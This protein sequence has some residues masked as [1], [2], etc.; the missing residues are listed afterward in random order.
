MFHATP[1]V[2]LLAGVGDSAVR[3]PDL[4]GV[5]AEKNNLLCEIHG[6]GLAD[7]AGAPKKLGDLCN[8]IF[9]AS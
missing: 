7:P 9:A 3:V 6:S 2:P 4:Q 8:K 1:R 5:S